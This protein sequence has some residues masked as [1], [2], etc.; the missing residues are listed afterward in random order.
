MP[1]EAK[2]N[3]QGYAEW[4]DRILNQSE[5]Y[6]LPHNWTRGTPKASPLP[7]S[8]TYEG[9]YYG[10]PSELGPKFHKDWKALWVQEDSDFKQMMYHK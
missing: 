3:R 5:G 7:T 8:A 4:V 1:K 10:H 6:R 2:H 9:V